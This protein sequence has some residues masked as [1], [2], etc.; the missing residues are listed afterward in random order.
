MTKNKIHKAIDVLFI[1]LFLL[2]GFVP[3]LKAM[4]KIATQFFYLSILSFFSC[5][6]L[7][8]T[9]DKVKFNFASIF[10]CSLSLLSIL[11]FSSYLYAVNKSE[12][13]IESSRILIYLFSFASLFLIINR[14]K[15][16]I[17]YIPYIISIILIIEIVY[18]FERFFERYTWGHIL[19]IWD[20]ELSQGI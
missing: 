17:E 9:T 8:L 20:L 2:V 11:G 14:N 3:Y 5:L 1:L 15:W 13:L 10:L 4:D 16:L 12:V 18:V 19:E 7:I 6:Y